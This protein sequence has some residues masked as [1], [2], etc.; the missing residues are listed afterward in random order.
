MKIRILSF[1]LFAVLVGCTNK[2]NKSKRGEKPTQEVPVKITKNS[3]VIRHIR[4]ADPSAHIWKDGRV[5][6]YTS[7]DM[8]DAVNYNTMDGYHAF[9]S[10]D[11]IN[12]TDHGEVLH[13]K[14][15][16]WGA[17]GWMWAPTAI[18]KN[19]KYYL[20]YPHS[21]KGI[22]DDMRCGVAISDV[23]EDLLKI[24]ARLKA[25]KV[26]GLTLA[27]SQMPMGEPISTGV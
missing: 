22:K 14:D 2:Q 26:D 4:T 15:I 12:W 11:M 5:W 8:E 21:V 17:K 27:Y 9:S 16:P 23:L 6:M 1:L 13:S 7:H 10:T 3:P 25:L 18:Y 24:L 19:N 20:I